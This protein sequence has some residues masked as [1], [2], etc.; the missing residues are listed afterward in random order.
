VKLPALNDPGEDTHRVEPVH[1]RLH[2]SLARI[3]MPIN[4]GLS[5]SAK[6]TI[7]PHQQPPITGAGRSGESP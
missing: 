1:A 2:C 4:E 6:R 3:V 5:Y 7:S